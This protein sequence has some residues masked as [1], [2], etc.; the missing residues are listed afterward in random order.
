MAIGLAQNIFATRA[1]R[2]IRCLLVEPKKGWSILGLSK[3]AG[4]SYAHAY[5]VIQTLIRMGLCRRSENYRIMARVKV[6]NPGEL[7]T[8]WANIHE[9]SLMNKVSSYYSEERNVEK[10]LDKLSQIS[11]KTGLIYALT[12]H[13][14]ANLVAPF[15]RPVDIHFYVRSNE[16]GTWTKNLELKPIEF[17]GNIHLVEPYDEGVFYGAQKRGAANVVSNVQLYIDLYNYPARGREAAEHLRRTVI[18]F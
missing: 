1:T 2:V 17:G 12:L 13:A 16:I 10:F 3:T 18:G 4:V 8:R 14:G 7:L 11:K 6:V 15:V 9:Y 5:K